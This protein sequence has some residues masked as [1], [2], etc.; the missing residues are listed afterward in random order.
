M[1]QI[2]KVVRTAKRHTLGGWENGASR[3][4]D[5]HLDVEPSPPL[6]GMPAAVPREAAKSPNFRR[7]VPSCVNRSEASGTCSKAALKP[8]A[9]MTCVPCLRKS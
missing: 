5:G 7:D 2:G 4:F 9:R 1:T 3:S 6:F 8:T